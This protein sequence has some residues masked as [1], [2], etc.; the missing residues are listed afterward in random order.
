[1]KKAIS[2]LLCFVLTLSVFPVPSHAVET[3]ETEY[4]RIISLACSL[5]PEYTSYLLNKNPRINSSTYTLAND[6]IIY[7]ETKHISD[8][9]SLSLSVYASGNTIL[10]NAISSYVELTCPSSSVNDIGSVGVSGTATFNVVVPPFYEYFTL[11]GVAFTIYYTGSDYF[12]NTGSYRM[13]NGV[14]IAGTTNITSTYIHYP[15]LFVQQPY[16]VSFRLYFDND[17]LVAAV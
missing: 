17:K 13:S 6:E 2:I 14:S 10:I 8:S 16:G 5:F 4:D 1:M 12:S 7:S 15:L 9:E 3:T 11:S